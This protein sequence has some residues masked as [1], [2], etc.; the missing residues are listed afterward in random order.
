MNTKVNK[1]TKTPYIVVSPRPGKQCTF[2][3]KNQSS[4]TD[5][6]KTQDNT[7]THF[8]QNS[9]WW[10]QKD[11]PNTWVRQENSFQHTTINRI[12]VPEKGALERSTELKVNREIS[13]YKPPANLWQNK[14]AS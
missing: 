10:K 3:A 9:L 11:R 4:K 5:K 2:V 12:D 1:I 14:L 6:D 7:H 8:V 13:I